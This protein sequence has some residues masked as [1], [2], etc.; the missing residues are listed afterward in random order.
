M[1]PE[2][3]SQAVHTGLTATPALLI[4][5]GSCVWGQMNAELRGVGVRNG[6]HRGL[7]QRGQTAQERSKAGLSLAAAPHLHAALSPHHSL[8]LGT[9]LPPKL[10][11]ICWA[12]F[13]QSHEMGDSGEH[14]GGRFPW[15]FASP[16]FIILEEV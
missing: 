10:P 5:L 1:T 6:P 2:V 16:A 14:A 12:G 3:F 11:Q 13:S 9:K 15:A 8:R 7:N 4:T